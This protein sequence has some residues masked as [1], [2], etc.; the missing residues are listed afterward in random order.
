MAG[1]A[2]GTVDGFHRSQISGAMGIAQARQEALNGV[3]ASSQD[4]A[5]DRTETAHLGARDEMTR[6]TR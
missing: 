5:D 3:H 4:E 6:M 2:C 1:G